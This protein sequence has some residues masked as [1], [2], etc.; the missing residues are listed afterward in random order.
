MI[1]EGDLKL[2]IR[3]TLTGPLVMIAV[4]TGIGAV[5][6]TVAVPKL[7]LLLG[8]L[9]IT[10]PLTTRIAISLSR[11]LVQEWPRILLFLGVL[12][13]LF[14]IAS[15]TINSRKFLDRLLLRSPLTSQLVRKIN[16]AHTIE[17]LNFL[18]AKG[19][20]LAESLEN[21]AGATGNFYYQDALISAAQKVK[22]GLRAS[23]ALRPYQ[24]LFPLIFIQMLEVGEDTGQLPMV[25]EKLGYFFN[26][27]ISRDLKSLAVFAEL[28]LMVLFGALV[29]FFAISAIQP[30]I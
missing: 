27:E 18:M 12:V 14:K 15:K 4:M 16:T 26:D 25:L 8:K 5:I 17:K 24:Y 6:L 13:F 3:K 28:V 23:E 29:G 7:S 19:V 20:S 11:F 22:S 9:E 30:L 1:K 2:K 21:I 10:P